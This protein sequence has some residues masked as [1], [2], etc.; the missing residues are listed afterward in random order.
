MRE[1]ESRWAASQ[2][3]EA[4]CMLYVALTRSKARA[5]CAAGTAVLLPTRV[6]G[7]AGELAEETSVGADGKPRLWPINRARRDWLE[8][9]PQCPPREGR[10]RAP[11]RLAARRGAPRTDDA[12]RREKE[13]ARRNRPFRGWNGVRPRGA[14]RVRTKSA[15]WTKPNRFYLQR[16]AGSD[17]VAEL[18][19]IP[20]IRGLFERNNQPIRRNFIANNLSMR[21]TTASG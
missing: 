5:L 9:I 3:Y 1:A 11:P 15:G 7:V 4:F 6:I 19:G 16:H 20:A 21:S 12:E 2:R 10:R 8:N 17:A 18:L 13:F 14:C